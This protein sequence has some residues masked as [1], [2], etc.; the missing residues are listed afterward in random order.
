MLVCDRYPPGVFTLTMSPELETLDQLL[1]SDLLLG[2]VLRLY[3]DASA[4]K[5][6]VLGLITCGDV[7][8]F[9]IDYIKV[10]SWRCSELFVDGTVMQELER[11]KLRITPQ[12]AR[13]IA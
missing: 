13:R 8:L 6:G 1:G 10:P 2:V 12:G 9:T 3:P 11:M 4:F 7:C 5:R